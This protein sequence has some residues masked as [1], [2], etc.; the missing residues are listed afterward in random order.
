MLII[1]A[2]DLKDGSVVRYVQGHRDKKVYSKDPVKTAAHWA[3]LGAPLLH[4]VDLDGAFSGRPKHLKVIEKIVQHI[5]VPVEC[6][7]GIRTLTTI[8]DLL[9]M[10]VKRVVLGTK[11][12]EDEKFLLKAYAL[13]KEKIIVSIDTKSQHLVIKGWKTDSSVK[14][15]ADFISELKSLGLKEIIYT[16]TLKDGT[17]KGPNIKELLSLLKLGIKIV[18]S[19][20]IATLEDIAALKKYEHKGISGIIIGKAL[21]EERFTLSQALQ[22]A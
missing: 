19:G 10:G 5:T 4:V 16:D 17:L 14:R 21:Y 7:G 13:F 15:S 2:I 18:A 20:G 12:I 22:Y 8:K 1:P 3:K 9:A 6:G 11:A